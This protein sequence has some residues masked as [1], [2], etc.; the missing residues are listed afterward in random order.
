MLE[1]IV[2]VWLLELLVFIFEEE[3]FVV[4]L[5]LIEFLVKLLS[6]SLLFTCVCGKTTYGG[7]IGFGGGIIGGTGGGGK[8]LKKG[9]TF[10]AI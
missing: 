10:L 8:G 7:A 4:V 2:P 9:I 5:D 1:V 6:E 3:L